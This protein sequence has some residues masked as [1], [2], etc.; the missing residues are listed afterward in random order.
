M[1]KN[2][3]LICHLVWKQGFCKLTVKVKHWKTSLKKT[4]FSAWARKLNMGLSSL[5][6]WFELS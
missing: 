3:F 5:M 6:S 2:G 1:G 4:V